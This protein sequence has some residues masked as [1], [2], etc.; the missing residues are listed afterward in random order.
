MKTKIRFDPKAIKPFFIENFEK[1]LFG[2]VV[3]TFIGFVYSAFGREKLN[4]TPDQLKSDADKARAHVLAT[5]PTDIPQKSPYAAQAKEL[6]KAILPDTYAMRQMT[7]VI[8][9][10]MRPREEPALFAIK[11]LRVSVGKGAFSM[12]NPEDEGIEA[13]PGG[14]GAGQTRG[15]RWV[16]IT[17]LIDNGAQVDAFK[18]AFDQAAWQDAAKDFPSYKYIRIERAEVDP[19]NPDSLQW[20]PIHVKK[21]FSVADY[22]MSQANVEVVDERF[23]PL[24]PYLAYPL[25]PLTDRLWG[26][27]VAHEPEVTLAQLEETGPEGAGYPGSG[28]PGAMRKKAADKKKAAKGNEE[29]AAEPEEDLAPEKKPEKKKPRRPVRSA[30]EPDEPDDAEGGAYA[31]G[32]EGP[33][34]AGPA[35][36]PPLSAGPRMRPSTGGG[37][38]SMPAGYPGRRGPGMTGP[39]GY[40]EMEEIP[41]EKYLLFRFFD[42]DVKEGKHYRY[43]VRLILDNPNREVDPKYLV[44]QESSKVRQVEADWSTPSPVASVPLDSHVLTLAAAG[45]PFESAGGATADMIVVRF[46]METGLEAFQEFKGLARGKWLNF[47]QQE[48]VRST[49]PGIMGSMGGSSGPGGYGRSMEEEDK[50]VVDYVTD[51]LLLDA[52]GGQKLPGREKDRLLEPAS[53]LLVDNNGD[54]VVRHELDDQEEVFRHQPPE[55]EAAGAGGMAGPYVPSTEGPGPGPGSRRG[56][57]RPPTSSGPPLAGYEGMSDTMPGKKGKKGSAKGSN[58]GSPSTATMGSGSGSPGSP[59][60]PGGYPYGKPGKGPKGSGPAGSPSGVRP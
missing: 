47:L 45:K 51:C 10:P 19:A 46:D 9:P 15:Q 14:A 37:S 39:E 33:M 5:K 41:I 31:G 12:A 42:F 29:A 11:D 8:F 54:L 28:Y 25:G 38:R 24:N 57:I 53:L 3:L 40:A 55:E 7:P 23:L 27:E 60:M 13:V 43:R 56:G 16:V 20:T 34:R 6:R 30:D 49:A 50:E 17:G 48:F 35:T 22:W 58:R 4:F 26:P 52:A 59:P 21:A 2:L 18:A 32:S 44:K 1:I 36:R